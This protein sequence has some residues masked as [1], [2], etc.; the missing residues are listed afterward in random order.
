VSNIF[1]TKKKD[2]TPDFFEKIDQTLFFTVILN[3]M[4][5]FRQCS[6]FSVSFFC[7]EYSST[8]NEN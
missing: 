2:F 7:I 3:M 8:R 5:G 1:F 6:V 4:M